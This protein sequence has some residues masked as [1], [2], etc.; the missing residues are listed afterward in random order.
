MKEQLKINGK[1]IA[2]LLALLTV[3]EKAAFLSGKDVWHLAEVP[4]L[5]IESIMVTDGP[6]GL[7]KQAENANNL[8]L[9]QSVPAICFPTASLSACSWDVDLLGEM[10]EAIGEEALAERISVVLGPGVNMKRSPLCGR[11]FEYFSEDPH[12]AG[13]LTAAFINGVQSKDVG[14]SLKHFAANNQENRRLSVDTVVDER[15]LR[16]I[17]LPAF[18]TAVKK[19]QPR[20]VMNCYNKVNGD[21]GSENDWLQNKVLREEWGF[22]G[23]VVSD[24]GAVNNRVKGVKAGNDLEMPSSFGLN[25]KK[26]LAALEAGTAARKRFGYLCGARAGADCQIRLCAAGASQ[27]RCYGAPRIR[28]TCRGGIHGAAQERR[29]H[30]AAEKRAEN[31]RHRRNGGGAALSRVRQLPNQSHEARQCLRL[32]AR[33]GLSLPIRARL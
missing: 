1:T 29:E 15:A 10:G 17:Y 33:N 25:T 21:H 6:H 18:E 12:L 22:E 8:G 20:T 16:E 7:R 24:W 28:A 9:G 26:L 19:A 14:T 4:R 32:P 3:E 30:S 31:R 27:I 13:E 2:E 5:G 11:N 23:L